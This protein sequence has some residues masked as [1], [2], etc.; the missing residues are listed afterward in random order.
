MTRPGVISRRNGI[1][2][3]GC[4]RRFIE[5]IVRWPGVTRPGSTCAAPI[6]SND[7]YPTILEA[8]GLPPEPQHHV[9][10]SSFVPLL[11]GQAV[12]RGPLY[13]HYPHYHYGNQGVAP[14]SALR[15]GHWK[16]IEWQEDGAV[17]LFDLEADMGETRNVAEQNAEV[18]SRL[19]QSLAQW[20]EEVGAKPATPNPLYRP[21]R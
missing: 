20:R 21:P 4:C 8:T 17:E 9:D 11:R 16:L 18:V 14:A 10:G 3:R 6:I 19:R 5:T 7:Y 1:T 13:W 15:D 2:I 12:Q